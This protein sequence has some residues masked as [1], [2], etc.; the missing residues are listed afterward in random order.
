MAGIFMEYEGL[1]KVAPGIATG[2]AWAGS[3]NTSPFAGTAAGHNGEWCVKHMHKNGYF[4]FITFFDCRP[5]YVQM[6]SCTMRAWCGISL[7]RACRL[8]EGCW[9]ARA[10]WWLSSTHRRLQLRAVAVAEALVKA[11]VSLVLGVRWEAMREPLVLP[12]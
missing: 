2:G 8:A 11:A 3:S 7:G 10:Q 4:L 6:E 12:M 1:L 9:A 5:Y